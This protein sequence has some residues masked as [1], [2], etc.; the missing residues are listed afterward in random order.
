MTTLR[1]TTTLFPLDVRRS[2][3]AEAQVGRLLLFKLGSTAPRIHQSS[4]MAPNTRSK[5]RAG[6]D[7]S[8][9]KQ[10]TLD[11]DGGVNG[12]E[13]AREENTGSSR[14]APPSKKKTEKKRGADDLVNPQERDKGPT[15]SR[16]SK[17]QKQEAAKVQKLEGGADEVDEKSEEA[18]AAGR[19]I[20]EKGG[21]AR[22][23]RGTLESG[24]IYFFYK[25]KV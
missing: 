11:A 7:A 20:Y 22:P 23:A 6:K 16:P 15:S 1:P 8:P 18:K 24:H 12:S 5:A 17:K 19:E 4:A 14:R 3:A 9:S 21:T 13:V 10:A 2:L 25:P